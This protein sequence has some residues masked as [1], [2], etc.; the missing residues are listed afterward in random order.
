MNKLISALGL[1]AVVF[2]CNAA[3][4]EI[5]IHFN[6]IQGEIP[7]GPWKGWSEVSTVIQKIA[8]P[9]VGQGV[10][11]RQADPK[12]EPI[13]V[14]KPLDKASP[15]LAEGA[16]TGRV[17]DR[18]QIQ[19]LFPSEK[20]LQPYYK[21]DLDFVQITELVSKGFEDTEVDTDSRARVQEKIV[22]DFERI[23]VT[24]WEY[25]EDGALLGRVKYLWPR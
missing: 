15:K 9:E 10:A 20:G 1:C 12:F 21:L 22:L 7:L 23:E 17:Y 14:I 3:Q 8:R 19:W 24:Y 25:D 5:Y 2:G 11:S 13:E 16:L 4:A 6:G 18:V